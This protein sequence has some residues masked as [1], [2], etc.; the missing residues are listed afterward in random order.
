MGTHR[1]DNR[2]AVHAPTL[3]GHTSQPHHPSLDSMSLS[4]DCYVDF[5]EKTLTISQRSRQ[6]LSLCIQ[7]VIQDLLE[8][9]LEH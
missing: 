3:Q 4:S 1:H 6:D 2:T 7:C 5:K 9:S 8:D